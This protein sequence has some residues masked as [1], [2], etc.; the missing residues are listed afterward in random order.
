MLPFSALLGLIHVA[1]SLRRR[2]FRFRIQR[3][4]WF[5]RGYKI[6]VSLRENFA[7]FYVNLWIMDP[8]VDSR[9][10]LFP[11]TTQCLVRPWI[12]ILRQ[13]TENFTFFYVIWWTMDPEVDYRPSLFPYT[14]QC[15]VRPW[16]QI[17]RQST[18]N[19]TF[20]YVNWW[21]TDP[22]VDSRRSFFPYTVHCLVRP[23]TQVLRQSTENFRLF[24]VFGWTRLLRTILV[25]LCGL[26]CLRS[27]SRLWKFL[28]SACVSW[29]G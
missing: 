27:W 7:F 19:F 9:P 8:E 24:N 10:S 23:W 11:F 2:R 12:Q 29:T 26:S 25:L 28:S 13:S 15:L 3:N 18:E 14:T 21:I 6:C 20:F 16:I 22:E 4:A 5:D 17:L 1:A